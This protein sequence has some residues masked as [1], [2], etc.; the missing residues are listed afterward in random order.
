MSSVANLSLLHLLRS[1][2]PNDS[3]VILSK[4]RDQFNNLV[5]YE[6]YVYRLRSAKL[7]QKL[8]KR[9]KPINYLFLISPMRAGSTLLT[10]VLNGHAAISGYGESH[11]SY[12]TERDLLHLLARTEY[13]NIDFQ[14]TEAYVM[15]K[16][17]WNYDIADELLTSKNV[18]FLFLLRDPKANFKSMGQ[19]KTHRPWDDGVKIWEDHERCL[20][21]YRYR[22]EFM[23]DLAQR[24]N[25]PERCL[26]V[27]YEALLHETSETLGY[28]QHFLKL[29][30]PISEEYPVSQTSGKFRFG[31]PSANLKTGRILRPPAPSKQETE[32]PAVVAARQVYANH[33]E[34][35]KTC[36]KT[37]VTRELTANQPL[38]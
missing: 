36:C 15:D 28:I 23:A 11:V 16:M 33:L 25:D 20:D 10:H 35:F 13:H 37:T 7:K 32:S 27:E 31:D 4:F 21:Y 6:M 5:Q 14:G 22:L 3:R 30:T 12:K 8:A 34:T 9:Q 29:K 18:Y 26:L 17:V 1:I 24:V 38:G 19:L 2:L